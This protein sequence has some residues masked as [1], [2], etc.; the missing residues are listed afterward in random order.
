V[1][2]FFHLGWLEDPEFT[3]KVGV[4][5]TPY[6]G[7][8]P[9][10]VE[11]EVTDRLEVALQEMPELLELYSYSMQGLSMIRVEMKPEYWGDALNQLWDQMRK[12]IRDAT[13]QLPPGAG[14]PIINDDFSFVYGFVLAVT[15]D[16][17]SFKDLETVVKGLKKDLSLVPGVSRVELWGVQDKV[18]YVDVSEEQM[19]LLGVTSANLMLTLAQQNMVVDAGYMND[20]DQR[21]RV[22]PS[23]QFTKPEDIGELVIRGTLEEK[24]QPGKGGRR[25]TGEVIRIKDIGTVRAGYLEPPRTLMFFNGKPAIAISLANVAGGNIV[26]TGKAIDQRL[27]ELKPELPVGIEIHQVSWQSDLVY[28]SILDFM[29]N[30]GE[31]VL[32]VIGVLW[33]TMGWRMGL[34]IGTDLLFTIL[35]TFIVMALFKIDLHRVSLGALIIAL[36][37]MVDNSIVVADNFTVRLK[38]GMDRTQAAIESASLPAW[39]LLGATFIA[40]MA[41][42]PVFGSPSET[43]EYS[44][45]LFM[46]VGISLLLSWLV[47]EMITPLKCI[48]LLPDPQPGE[49]EETYSGGMYDK[50][51][52]LL[53]WAIRGRIFTIL[54]MVGLLAASIVGFQYVQRMFFPDS[55]RT[56]FM[57]DYWAPMGTPIQKV[58]QGLKPIEKF[59]M[60]DPQTK[61][62]STYIGQGPPRFYLPVD[63]EMPFSTYGQIIVNTKTLEG[64]KTLS[65]ALETWLNENPTDALV[66]VRLYSV[67][68]GDTWKFEA[69]FSGP[70]EA[71]LEYLR[72]LG[73]EGMNILK[74]TPLA[75]DV[76]T[77]MR[78]RVREIVPEYSQERGRWAIVDRDDIARSTKRAYDG[79]P[80][81]QYREGDT[82]YPILLRNRDKDRQQMPGALDSLQVDRKLSP[83]PVPLAQVT[84]GID[85]EWVDPIIMRFNRRRVNSVQASPNGVTFPTL[86][87]AVMDKFQEMEK[88]L[89]P[90]YAL[91]WDGEDYSTRRA[92]DGLNPGTIPATV[93][94]LFILVVLFNAVRPPLI[95]LLAIPFALIGITSGLLVTQMAFGFMAL[96]GAMS[97]AGM[98]L[99]NGIV[100]I[101]QINLELAGGK[102]PYTAVMDAAISR[103]RPVVNTA[104]TTV[105]GVAPLLQDA[106]WA[107]MSV[108]IMGGLAFGTIITM[109]LVPVL[110]CTLYKIPSPPQK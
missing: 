22:S 42:Y 79:L 40:I 67:G 90:G 75:K 14:P 38:Q 26:Q 55:S 62:V 39:A 71:D 6:P 29:I 2:S 66:R 44:G 35:G 8:S 94:I 37:M 109:V 107:S 98:M 100:L 27:E 28:N 15:G 72:Q 58:T 89:R 34:I 49:G 104:T 78:Q 32:I 13:P 64:V 103:L 1:F 97:L 61:N 73:V 91:F 12:K 23:G 17:F 65:T 5:V 54:V 57:V 11:L 105:L 52:G 83:R 36:G 70:A 76:R 101:D 25:R 85:T 95:L 108:T 60:K 87:A 68:P 45:S 16:G 3:V 102:A 21:Y 33:L 9:Q 96:L 69:R 110:Y 50:F 4:I 92:Q 53:T 51:R 30:L 80:V 31:A 19:S 74:A 10:E 99:K 82:V 48:A 84:R 63:P 56:Q 18:I 88:N 77:D 93:V 43:G 46:V 41:F 106:F 47:A 7:A 86:Q 81:G 59:L 20:R 24:L